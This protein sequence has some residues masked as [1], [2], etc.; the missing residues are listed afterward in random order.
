MG[1]VVRRNGFDRVLVDLNTQCDYFLPG[2]AVPVA[3][4]VDIIPNIRRLMEWARLQS[5]PVIS[6]INAHR[7]GD[8]S[9]LRGAPPHCIDRTPGQRKLP[10]TLLPRRILL[11]GDNTM[12]LP[13]DLFSRYRQVIFVKRSKD[14]VGNPKAD[15][16]ISELPARH[17]IVFGAIAEFCV[18]A[19]V[20]A[21]VTRLRNVIVVEDACGTWNSADAGISLRQMSAKGAFLMS[22]DQIINGEPLP[23]R[24]LDSTPDQPP[25]VETGAERR[26]GTRVRSNGRPYMPTVH[27]TTPHRSRHLLA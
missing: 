4:R 21:L 16:L 19:S 13:N 12:D 2:G 14:L 6:T 11:D 24:A 7:P 9:I 10:F 22:V 20:L 15:R 26:N 5:I 8:A 3:N 18:K 27:H 25:T 1:L 23:E 17:L